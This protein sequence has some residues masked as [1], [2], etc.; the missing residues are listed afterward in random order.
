MKVRR[1][2]G[3]TVSTIPQYEVWRRLCHW[4]PAICEKDRCVRTLYLITPRV[5][6]RFT[7]FS[8]VPW[9]EAPYSVIHSV[10]EVLS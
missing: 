5:A 6:T 9:I 3:C 2:P 8:V 7:D 10:Y 1:Q 4:G